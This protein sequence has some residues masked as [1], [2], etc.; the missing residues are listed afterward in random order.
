MSIDQITW[1]I[2]QMS[3]ENQQ[4]KD[5]NKQLEEQIRQMKLAEEKIKEEQK[6]KE[7]TEKDKAEL[8]ELNRCLVHDD[9]KYTPEQILSFIEKYGMGIAPEAFHRIWQKH[10]SLRGNL[11]QLA[12]KHNHLLYYFGKLHLIFQ[13]PEFDEE[14]SYICGIDN[15]L[16]SHVT[17]EEFGRE[18]ILAKF[19][20]PKLMEKLIAESL[21]Q[22]KLFRVVEFYAN[23]RMLKPEQIY[24]LLMAGFKF[25]LDIMNFTPLLASQIANSLPDQE[26]FQ[27]LINLYPYE[28]IRG[29]INMLAH[30]I[31]R[32]FI[33]SIKK[34]SLI[35]ALII[36]DSHAYKDG[37]DILTMYE[38]M[39]LNDRLIFALHTNRHRDAE[40]FKKEIIKSYKDAHDDVMSRCY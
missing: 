17:F 34:I 19:H 16:M 6:T 23:R 31:P 37:Y 7:Q 30:A 1:H 4:L 10:S 38:K 18:K 9:Y 33:T 21:R 39:D 5:K 15:Q 14:L 25:D 27:H 24:S 40:Q 35:T 8:A 36:D 3:D 29:F 32:Q 11:L 26:V 28:H 2:K 22:K 20:I 12:K 13:E